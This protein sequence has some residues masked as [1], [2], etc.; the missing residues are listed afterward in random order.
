MT[1]ETSAMASS[2]SIVKFIQEDGH[3]S[4]I[5]AFQ[6][7]VASYKYS[8]DALNR[9]APSSIKEEAEILIWRSKDRERYS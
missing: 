5:E 4:V 9:E 8:Y 3:A 1:R 2:P 6:E 7:F